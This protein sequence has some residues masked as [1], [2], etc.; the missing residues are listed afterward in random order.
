MIFDKLPIESARTM[1]ENGYLHVAISN[2]T[3]E[4]V[5]PY[6]GDTIP[7]WEKLGLDPQKVYMLYRPA[8]E[9]EK[10]APTFNGLPLSLD[11]WDM[12]ASNLPHDKI[13]GS[14]GTD[15]KFEAPYLTNSLTITDANAIERVQSGEFRDISAGYMCDVEMTGGV[16]GGQSYDGVM[17]NIRGNHVALV[18]EGRAGHDVRV[19]DSAMEGGENMGE[20]IDWKKLAMSFMEALKNGGGELM[21]ETKNPNPEQNP[22]PTGAMNTP[23]AE[24]VEEAHDEDPVDVLADEIR[25]QMK[26]AGLDPEDKAA[27]KAFLA[28]MAAAK[29]VEDENVEATETPAIDAEGCDETGMAKDSAIVQDRAFYAGLYKAA[30]DVAPFVGKISNPFAFDS[31]AAIYKK[32]LDARGVATDGV[33]PSAYGAMV[34]MLSRPTAIPQGAPS[35]D[36]IN[37]KLM[38]IKSY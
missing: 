16:F 12:D 32:A 9:L 29:P 14:L 26:A 5:V 31:A 22:E 24:G 38:G 34:S 6:M 20:K 13:V 19:A 27:Q 33:D 2:I 25:E 30:E 23:P 7:G 10:A 18:R 8:E 4:Q 15:A 11:H 28:G 3:K 21:D 1:D 37:A 35:E 17:R 36:P